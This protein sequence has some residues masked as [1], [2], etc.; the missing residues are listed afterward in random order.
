MKLILSFVLPVK[1]GIRRLVR[2]GLDTLF[3][4]DDLLSVNRVALFRQVP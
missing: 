4:G 1:A 2:Y 3:C